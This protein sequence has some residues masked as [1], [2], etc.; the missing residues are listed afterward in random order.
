MFYGRFQGGGSR[1]LDVLKRGSRIFEYLKATQPAEGFDEV[2][3]PGEIE[4]KQ[5]MERRRDGIQVEDATC[6]TCCLG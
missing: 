1:P 3:Y 4:H 6:K 2:L 5:E